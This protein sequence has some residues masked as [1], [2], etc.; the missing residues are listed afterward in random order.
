MIGCHV[1]CFEPNPRAISLLQRNIAANGLNAQVDIWPF[2]L[3]TAPGL[4]S[5]DLSLAA[6]NLG[7][8]QLHPAERGE[9]RAAR[10]DQIHFGRVIKL[11][12]IDV[13]GMELDV[14]LGAKETI[15]RD[16]PI[17]CVECGKVGKFNEIFDYLS[18][19]GFAVSESH[20]YTATHAFVPD[21]ESAK[22][23]ASLSRQL[24]V[25]YIVQG[26]D[27]HQLQQQVQD[28]GMK[29]GVLGSEAAL[30][31]QRDENIRRDV[32]A[33]HSQFSAFDT[34]T[35]SST[36]EE[37]KRLLQAIQAMLAAEISKASELDRE[38][39]ETKESLKST[40]TLVVAQIQ[41][42]AE[43]TRELSEA[44]NSLKS[45]QAKLMTKAKAG[46]RCF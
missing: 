36:A 24:A 20:N 7:A 14:L 31:A 22:L 32:E 41:N 28:I 44:N 38:L 45:I 42:V 40:R 12:K 15:L 27:I 23:A 25:R 3:G 11:I 16:R 18:A 21:G 8:V 10:L 2:A 29:M 19:L 30:A 34:A 6:H 13:E 17:I 35:A 33:I 1:S 43:L 26:H 9:I 37:N 5:A 4:F 46:R 39:S